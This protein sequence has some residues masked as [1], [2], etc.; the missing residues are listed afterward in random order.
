MKDWTGKSSFSDPFLHLKLAGSSM[1]PFPKDIHLDRA[2]LGFHVT[3]GQCKLESLIRSDTTLTN[4]NSLLPTIQTYLVGSICYLT[5]GGF[6]S[7]SKISSRLQGAIQHNHVQFVFKSS[8]QKPNMICNNNATNASPQ[9][10]ASD[11][12]KSRSDSLR[13][14]LCTDHYGHCMDQYWD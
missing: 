8:M 9:P 5:S 1:G 13:W 6:L 2:S 3:L 4:L 10:K 11:R 14:G 12:L 7:G